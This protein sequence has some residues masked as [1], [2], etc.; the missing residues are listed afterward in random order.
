MQASLDTLCTLAIAALMA[1]L[2]ATAFSL[3][4][5]GDPSRGW[6]NGTYQ[7]GYEDRF[8]TSVPAH[9][10]AVALWSAAKWVL[11][12]E[13]A[14]GA[15]SG[16]D[17]W[18]FT[19]EEFTEPTK[20]R[21]LAQELARA[22][23]ALAVD[24]IVLVPVIVPDKAR[25]HAHRLKR[26]R[27]EGFENR[28]DTALTIIREAGLIEVDLRDALRFENSFMRTDTH[29]RPEGA[30]RAAWTVANALEHLEIPETQVDT[31][32]TGIR[33]FDGDLLSF[34]ATGHYRKRVGPAP[35]TISLFETRVSPSGGLFGAPDI[36]IAL[37]GTSYSAK[38]DFHFEGFL[39]QAMQADVLNLGR[40]G[41][42]PFKPMDA[43]LTER[44]TLSSLPTVVVWEIPER[45]LTSRSPR[46]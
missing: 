11:F 46:S 32:A 18:L 27:S 24:G 31:D 1:G 23:K 38:T 45:F 26:G 28:Y 29:W 13:P 33:V 4:E 39:K 34:V 42:G 36:P 15:V 8:E 22:Q 41:Q 16:R 14:D 21:D 35:E 43:F 5:T 17:G 37:V 20:T 3:T 6:A 12:Q 25:M 2:S 44:A 40:V 10:S 7:R 9:E 19:A 30:R